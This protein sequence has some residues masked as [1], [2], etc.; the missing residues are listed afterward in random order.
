MQHRFDGDTVETG[1][2]KRVLADVQIIPER[3]EVV[4]IQEG[5]P[6]RLILDERYRPDEADE[7]DIQVVQVGMLILEQRRLLYGSCYLFP[8]VYG[9]MKK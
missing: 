4:S 2:E 9:M 6:G 8:A 1:C 7:P 5:F 3:L